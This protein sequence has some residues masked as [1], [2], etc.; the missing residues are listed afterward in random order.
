MI[1]AKS[2]EKLDLD[3]YNNE[4]FKTYNEVAL[5]ACHNCGRTFL[6]DRL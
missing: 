5:V 3:T 2:G 4:A 1:G 6:P